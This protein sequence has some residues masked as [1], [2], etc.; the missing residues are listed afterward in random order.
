VGTTFKLYFPELSDQTSVPVEA[1]PVLQVDEGGT[2]TI[3]LVEDEEHLRAVVAETLRQAGY[4][5]LE[6]QD[7]GEAIGFC[8]RHGGR[9][10]LL[11]SDVVMPGMSGRRVS[12]VAKSIRSDISVLYMSGYTDEAVKRHGVLEPNVPFLQKPFTPAKLRMKVREALARAH[13]HV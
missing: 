6:A 1:E 8:T 4:T 11:L 7:G 2:E 9:I 12:D 5:V 3:L 10:D 13:G